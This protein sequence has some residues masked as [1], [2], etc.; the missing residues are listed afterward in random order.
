MLV[1]SWC[2][3]LR[4][5]IVVSGSLSFCGFFVLPQKCVAIVRSDRLGFRV[6]PI[7]DRFAAISRCTKL[8][9]P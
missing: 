6:E 2:F 3:V 9:P 5:V 8:N 1:A 4:G 7:I